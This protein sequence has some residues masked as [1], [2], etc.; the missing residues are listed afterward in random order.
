[1][2]K[3]FSKILIGLSSLMLVYMLYQGL[4]HDTSQDWKNFDQ[5]KPADFTSL[6]EEEAILERLKQTLFDGSKPLE[7]TLFTKPSIFQPINN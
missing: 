4:I 2:F 6:E 5:P 7:P 3:H 1:M